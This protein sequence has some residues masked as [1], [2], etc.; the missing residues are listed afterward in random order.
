MASQV[1]IVNRA[2]IKLGAKTISDMTE[3]SVSAR[4]MTALYDTV[5]RSELTKR[6]WNFSLARAQL[7]RLA[8]DPLYGFTSAYQLPTDF[9]KV[10]QVGDFYFD[11]GI[12]DYLTGD[13]SPYAIEGQIINT[14]YGDPLPLRYVKDITDPGLF[15]SM[16]IECFASK[17]AYEACYAITQSNQGRSDAMADYKIALKEGSLSNAIAKPPQGIPDTSWITTRL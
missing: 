13:N 4:T 17:L 5:R 11:P 2:L 16:F 14:F 8:S 9:L 7:A 1:E 6:Y 12:D 10:V 15:D 3:S